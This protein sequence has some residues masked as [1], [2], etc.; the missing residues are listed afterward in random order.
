MKVMYIASSYRG[1]G[2]VF[3]MAL[4]FAF[5]THRSFAQENQRISNAGLLTAIRLPRM[6]NLCCGL[7]RVIP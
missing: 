4:F 5:A 6:G 1:R 3:F 7:R 2:I